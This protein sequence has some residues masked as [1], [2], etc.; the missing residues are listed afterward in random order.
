MQFLVILSGLGSS[1]L[2]QI[3][4]LQASTN[5]ISNANDRIRNPARWTYLAICGVG[6]NGNNANCNPT[7]AALPFDVPRN[8]GTTDGVPSAFVDNRSYYFYLS[9][10]AWVFYL[11]ALFFVVIALFLSLFALIAR[12]GAYLTGLMAFLGMFFQTLAAALM[13]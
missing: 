12:L 10:F 7:R 9:R 1:P 13:T 4:F 11:V 2:N 5:G 6:D 3:Y 8:F